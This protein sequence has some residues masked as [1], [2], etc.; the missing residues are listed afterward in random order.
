MSLL[1]CKV[2]LTVVI[3]AKFVE[4]QVEEQT[5]LFQLLKIR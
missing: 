5:L 1:K 2:N 4:L 3:E